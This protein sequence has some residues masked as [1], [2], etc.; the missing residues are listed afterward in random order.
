MRIA[1]VT[2]S[3]FP[4]IGGAETVVHNLASEWVKQGHEVCVFNPLTNK[5]TLDSAGYSVCKFFRPYSYFKLAPHRFPFSRYVARNL[6]QHLDEFNPDFISAHFG[7]PIGVWLSQLQPTPKFLVTCHGREITKFTWGYRNIYKI[8][9]VLADALNKSTGA[10]AIS[11]H[12]RKLMEE[13]G[14]RSEKI[15]DIPNGVD[16]E[17]FRNK[18]EGDF[19]GRFGLPQKATVVLSVGREHPQ[20]AYD[21]GIKAFAEVAGR[22]P[23]TYYVI[24]GRGSGK[25]QPV[26]MDMGL[27]GRIILS[28]GLS[29]DDLVGAYQQAD[30]FFSPS[31]WELMPLVVLEA[32]ASGLPL[33]VTN[34]SGSQ[35][36]VQ[37]G[38]NGMVVE[39]GDP[40]EMTRA[41]LQLAEDK[42]MRQRMGAVNLGRSDD[43]SWDRISR[44]YL[45]HC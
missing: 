29:G 26:V 8:D 31:A 27:Q 40:D 28:E 39:P 20:K 6:K 44:M 14:V 15:L 17:R 32:M 10:V 1:L 30:I 35:D 16:I 41:I 7:Y 23:E 34:V 22:N 2:A 21:V 13:M 43:Y 5:P 25:W 3:F 36:L 18:A 45:E 11:R 38:E 33:V 12:A 37:S 9:R 19:R 4:R 42:R 24:L